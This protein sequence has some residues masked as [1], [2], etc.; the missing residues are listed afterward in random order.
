MQKLLL[1]S[2]RKTAQLL[3]LNKLPYQKTL[4]VRTQ[5]FFLFS[6]IAGEFTISAVVN[7]A[8]QSQSTPFLPSQVRTISIHTLPVI[9]R[10]FVFPSLRAYEVGV[11]ISSHTVPV[12]VYERGNLFFT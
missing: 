4:S 7:E 11:A 9:A 12:I 10:E 3:N 1:L 5:G 2:L 8:W 6:V